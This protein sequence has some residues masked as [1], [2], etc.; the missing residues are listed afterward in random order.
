MSF[1]QVLRLSVATFLFI[2]VVFTIAVPVDEMH[3]NTPRY[4]DSNRIITIGMRPLANSSF[5]FLAQS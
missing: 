1:L 2:F 5:S 3:G 4:I